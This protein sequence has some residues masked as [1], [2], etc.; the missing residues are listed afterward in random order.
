MRECDNVDVGAILYIK[1]IK[2]KTKFILKFLQKQK[3]RG[4]NNSKRD[5]SRIRYATQKKKVRTHIQ[6]A[7]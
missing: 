5:R 1:N 6:F 2:Y 4:L 3:G 7:V